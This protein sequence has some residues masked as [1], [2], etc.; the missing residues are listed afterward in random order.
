MRRG[1][2]AI[3]LYVLSSVAQDYLNGA[4]EFE[5]VGARGH[6]EDPRRARDY[7]GVVNVEQEWGAVR[8]GTPNRV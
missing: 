6:V 7:L 4:I 8:Q 1:N 3:D 5:V 2:Y